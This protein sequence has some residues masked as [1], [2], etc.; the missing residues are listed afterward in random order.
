MW[1]DEGQWI[2]CLMNGDR[3]KV[4]GESML[5]TVLFLLGIIGAVFFVITGYIWTGVAT[6]AVLVPGVIMLYR[7]GR[8]LL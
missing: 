2:W 5:G 8:S 7:V 1:A 4:R 3:K 6:L